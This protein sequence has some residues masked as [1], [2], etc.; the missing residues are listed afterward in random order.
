MKQKE[1][2]TAKVLENLKFGSLNEIQNAM[3][4]ADLKASNIVLL[5]PTGS[6][7]TVAFL[8]PLLH[9][10]NPKTTGVQALI[11]VPSR[12]LALQIEQVFRSMAS[13]FKVNCCYG[14]HPMKTE[15]NNF[16][17]PPAVLIGTPGR[18]AAHLRRGSFEPESIHLL[19]LDEFDKSL[20][21]GFS[22]EMSYIIGLLPKIKKRILTSATQAI[23]IPDFSGVKNPVTLNYLTEENRPN[24]VLK[25]VRATGNDKLEILIKLICHIGHEP[26]L[27]FCNH[28]EA[29]D[30]I[31]EI[32]T[33][34]N[35][36]HDTFH[37]GLEQD[38]RERALLK[39]RNGSH[40]I[41]ITTD[42]ASRGLDIPEIKNIIHY[43]GANTEEGFIHRNGRTARMNAGGTAWLVL[44]ERES[45][46]DFLTVSPIFINLPEQI[47]LPESPLWITLYIGAGKKD[48]I[49]KTDIVGFLI[50]KG[51]LTKEEIGLITILDNA[52]F[53]AINRVKARQTIAAIKDEKVKN[54]KVRIAISN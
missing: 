6:G 42:L 30:R 46:P 1:D 51:N 8:L 27:V 9:Q 31:S 37:G 34:E 17:E 15:R 43:Q 22:D 28:R 16:S 44:A 13:G 39:F 52:S 14:G 26:T 7:K 49:S 12:E 53:V 40:Q 25:A 47:R 4:S 48:K 35:V 21:L 11:L 54:Q 38:E 41:L 3:I 33:E 10:F 23:E 36:V 18:I 19:V 24:I 20:E 32:L 5:A 50:Q 2:I 29:V 45:V